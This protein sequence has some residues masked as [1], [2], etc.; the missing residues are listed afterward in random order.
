MVNPAFTGYVKI[1]KTT[2]DPDIRAREVSSSTGVP[3]PYAVAWDAFVS[4]CHHVERLVHR[5]LAHA[6]ARNDRE[7]FAIPLREAVSVLAEVVT[8]YL[9][10]QGTLYRT[11]SA[12]VENSPPSPHSL[13]AVG[14]PP[15]QQSRHRHPQAAAREELIQASEDTKA[16][17]GEEPPDDGADKTVARIQFEVLAEN[18]Y[19]F[20]EHEFYYEVRVV[21]RK[22]TDLKL[23]LYNIKLIPLLKRYG[24]GIH[25][26]SEGK[27]ALVACESDRYE[28]LLTDPSVKKTR[29][30]R[31]KVP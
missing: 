1:G 13:G 22:R 28:E 14:T 2:K 17:R 30:Y 12:E 8:P 4:D 20:T 25:R 29:A 19:E 15:V 6:R 9:L 31:S 23:E 3:A 16:V 26:N 11:A 18:P 27:L 21:R 7:F 5:R 24:W 10:E